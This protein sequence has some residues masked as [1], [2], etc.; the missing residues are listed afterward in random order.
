MLREAATRCHKVLVDHTQSTEAHVARI[1][2]LVE[3]E[4]VIS[5]EPPVI[6]VPTLV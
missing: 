1:I 5:V 3:R 4:G 6:E 2:I